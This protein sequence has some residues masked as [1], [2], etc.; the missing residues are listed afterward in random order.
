MVRDS[1]FVEAG[2]QSNPGAGRANKTPGFNRA[3]H[4]RYT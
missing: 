4:P 3:G 1:V 2:L